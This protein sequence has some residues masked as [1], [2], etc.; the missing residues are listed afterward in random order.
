MLT[1]LEDE[2]VALS[3]VYFKEVM[4]KMPMLR[5]SRLAFCIFTI[6]RGDSKV[7]WE[8]SCKVLGQSL[9]LTSDLTR[10]DERRFNL[11]SSSRVQRI[12]QDRHHWFCRIR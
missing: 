5:N 9:Y 1:V 8:V 4:V 11:K 3:T 12:P 2:V 6:L 10:Q 7:S